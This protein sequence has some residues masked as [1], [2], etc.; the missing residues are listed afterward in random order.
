MRTFF[1][2]NANKVFFNRINRIIALAM[3]LILSAVIQGQAQYPWPVT[4]FNSSHYITGSFAEY[5]DTSPN[6]HFH[7]G[8][9]IPKADFSP[10]YASKNGNVTGLSSVGGNAYVRVN[11]LAYVHILPN[12][13]LSV[14]S[15]VIASQTILGTILPGYGHVHFKNGYPGEEKVCLL[16]NSGLTPY[17][18]TWAP[19]IRYIH[20]YEDNTTSFFNG[21]Q[22]NGLVDIIVKVDEQSGPPGSSSSLLNNG[23]YKI[24][25]KIFSADTSSIVFEPPNNGI[26]FEFSTIPSDTY[27]NTVYF[28]P[29]STTMSHVYQ[30]TNDITS[31]NSWNTTTLP[32]GDYIVMAFAE[33]TRGNTDTMYT[34]VTV[35]ETD[36][37][38]PAQ[39]AMRLVAETSNGMLVDWYANT[40][41]DLEGY[42]LYFSF[43]NEQWD[44]FRDENYLSAN[45]SDT[46]IPG[47]LNRDVYFRLTA[48]DNAP[49]SNE[50]PVSDSYGMSNGNFSHKIL[51]V[52]GF[53]RTTGAWTDAWHDFAVTHGQAI[54]EHDISFDTAPNEAIL[55][56]SV[57]L[58]G[59]DAVFW[60]LGDEEAAD[61]TFSA[62]EQTLVKDYLENGGYLFLSG[63]KVAWDLDP[64]SSSNASVEDG[65]FL[66]DYLKAAFADSSAGTVSV[67]GVDGSILQG[68]NF[69]FGQIPYFVQDADVI[70]PFA[71]AETILQYDGGPTAA[72]QYGGTFGAGSTPGKLVYFA[73]PFETIAS[74]SARFSVMEGVLDFFFDIVAINP[75]D[76]LVDG[77]PRRFSLQRNY[78]NPFNPSTTLAFHL[79]KSAEASLVIY[80]ALGQ[81]VRS[82]VSANLP[83]GIHTIN[84]DGRN[85]N[86]GSLPSGIYLA[87]FQA[88]TG[89]GSQAF[90]Q[91]RKLLMVK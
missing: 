27:V 68:L 50:S 14:G 25:Y 49:L 33:D 46:L 64:A 56:S 57:S 48:I 42:R 79:P 22:V 1:I 15:P 6:G 12:P 87:R 41:N 18:D 67:S 24:G 7:D 11:D 36:L 40:D 71:G 81:R 76:D 69:N 80:N 63:S 90:Q 58:D 32:L 34:A 55:D 88:N 84:W 53:D 16:P 45:V 47:I 10:V 86:G 4:P 5:R 44:L 85:D 23:M 78:P 70:T 54:I 83:A 52:D 30:V 29:Q 62:D 91:T 75:D 66:N 59:Y 17:T 60:I 38:P 77:L 37:T 31:N 73:F 39:P 61:E 74:E 72:I 19:I 65:Q 35:T 26:R 21:N 82:L 9:D 2:T 3:L 51:I 20:F 8:T 89:D 28:R 13:S 43:D